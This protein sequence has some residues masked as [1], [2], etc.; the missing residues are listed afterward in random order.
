MTNYEWIKSLSSDKLA[1][2]MAYSNLIW[3]EWV[4]DHEKIILEWLSGE[5]IE[6]PIKECVHYGTD[7]FFCDVCWSKTRRIDWDK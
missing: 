7:N 4:G 2:V 1:K 3:K 5:R 6:C